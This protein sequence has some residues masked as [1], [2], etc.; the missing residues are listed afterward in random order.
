MF[1][2]SRINIAFIYLFELF[3]VTFNILLLCSLMFPLGVNIPLNV[4]Y[5]FYH[6]YNLTKYVAGVSF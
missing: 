3:N 1:L 2:K 5:H 4:E 6:Q